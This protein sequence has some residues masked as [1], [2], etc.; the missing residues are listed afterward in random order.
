MKPTLTGRC[1]TLLAMLLGF[2]SGPAQ[3]AELKILSTIAFEGAFGAALPEFNRSSG[4]V[5]R[6]EFGG[7]GT[8]LERVQKDEV[9]DLYFGPRETVDALLAAGKLRPDSVVDVARS[10]M[11][12]AVRRGAQKPDISTAD[13]LR[14]A[15]LAARGITY[16]NP[17]GASPSAK[18]LVK[19]AARLGISEEL[20]ARTRRPPRGTAAGPLML[21]TGEVDLAVQQNCEL[22][23]F[24]PQIELLG[25]LPPEF[26]L[27]TIMSAAVPVTAR[28]PAAARAF[29]RY[30]LT[31]AAAAFMRR[32]ALE[33]IERGDATRAAAAPLEPDPSRGSLAGRAALP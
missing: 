27:I 32:W 24:A 28:E 16:P 20:Q 30:L 15:I 26:Q 14:R 8:I 9:A 33:P 18:Q 22:M 31:P 4:Q 17:D 21:T 2:S 3:A 10:P 5:A 23:M 12:M 11:G 13:G 6:A 1:V 19:I 25:P 29:L 7:A